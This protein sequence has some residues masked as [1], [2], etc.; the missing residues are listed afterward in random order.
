MGRWIMILKLIYGFM[1]QAYGQEIYPSHSKH[2]LQLIVS[3][4]QIHS[5]LDASGDRKWQS[6][7]SWG[8]NYNF[9]LSNKW[10]IGFH[11]DIIVEDFQVASIGRNESEVLDRRYPIAS[12]LVFSRK[13][14]RHFQLLLG[15]GGEFAESQSF[16]LLRGGVEYGYHFNENW[17]LITNLT[18]DFKWNAYN[19]W[20]IGLGVTRM[21]Q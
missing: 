4:T 18:N 21:I 13:L 2:Q 3:H 20:A 6:L 11:N 15:L 19:S 1:A 14:G 8:L 17:E 16:L 5:R 9:Q 10:K 12:A 7:P